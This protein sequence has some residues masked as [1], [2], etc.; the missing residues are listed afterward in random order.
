[1]SDRTDRLSIIIWNWQQPD[2]PQFTWESGRLALAE[3]EFLLGGGMLA[4]P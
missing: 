4:G 3:R 2:W 1:M